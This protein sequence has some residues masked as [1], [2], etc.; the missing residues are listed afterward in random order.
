M[1]TGVFNVSD[2][3]DLEHTLA[4]AWLKDVEYPWDVVPDIGRIVMEIGQGL[5]ADEYEQ[6]Y[7]SVWIHR[8]ASVSGSACFVGPCV[9]GPR[10]EV[11][12][13][14]FVRGGVLVGAD[15]VVGN[16]TELKNCILFD[17]CQVPHF[18][19]VGD[20][21]L[22]FHSHFGAGAVTS[23]VRADGKQVVVHGGSSF[24]DMVTGLSKLGAFVGDY[25]EVGCNSVLGPG[26]VVGRRSVVYPLSFVRG[27]VGENCIFKSNAVVVAKRC[28]S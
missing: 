18:N 4:K 21:V 8:S 13:C 19:Y 6:R 7:R 20:S 23:N 28:D 25:V 10:T 16:S 12:H 1:S 27:V 3:F 14:A 11:R 2:M 9:I 15:C 17:C 24:G 5:P 26:T 22:G